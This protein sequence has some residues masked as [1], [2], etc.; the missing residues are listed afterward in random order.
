VICASSI[1]RDTCTRSSDHAYGGQIVSLA[2]TRPPRGIHYRPPTAAPAAR[3]APDSVLADGVIDRLAVDGNRVA[4]VSC[5]RVDVWSPALQTDVTVHEHGLVRGAQPSLCVWDQGGRNFFYSLALAGGRVAY[6]ERGGGLT[7]GWTL[8][9]STLGSANGSVLAAGENSLGSNFPYGVAGTLAGS[10]SLLVYSFWHTGFTSPTVTE[11]EIRRV[12]EGGCPCPAIA[13]SP[14]PLV[15]FDVEG[16][17]I[18]AAGTNAT[19]IVDA[20]G[21]L[22]LSIPVSPLAAQLAG[23]DLVLLLRG[24]IDDYDAGSG[25]MRHAWPLPDVPSGAETG[26]PNR[27]AAVPGNGRLV[28]DDAGRGLVA[29]VL[30]E[31]VHVLRLSDGEDVTVA[32]GQLARFSDTGLVYA[33]GARI[34]LVPFDRLPLR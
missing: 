14:G 32:P 1:W 26:D 16:G 24:E 33:D 25:V 17:R 22:L 21:K 19:W 7:Y 13:S 10:G 11:Q 3:V 12:D 15:P 29:Y 28:L 8:A 30:D 34:H 23:S 4:Y 9:T 18:V 2:W 5:L 6:G 31:Q 27:V 20:Q